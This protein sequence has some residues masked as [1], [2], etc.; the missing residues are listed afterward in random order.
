MTEAPQTYLTFGTQ[1]EESDNGFYNT[2]DYIEKTYRNRGDDTFRCNSHHFARL[3]M[4]LGYFRGF[5]RL[6]CTSKHL[7]TL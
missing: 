3:E 1:G 7:I 4:V 5:A 6:P 2:R